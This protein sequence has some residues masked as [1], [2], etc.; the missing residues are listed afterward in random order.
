MGTV[1]DAL[2]NAVAESFF[3]TLECELLDRYDWPTRQ[4]LRTAVFDFLEVFYNRQRRH[5]TIDYLTPSTTST[6]PITSTRRRANLST[7]AGQ[8]QEPPR[9]RVVIGSW[10]PIHGHRSQRWFWHESSGCELAIF[11]SPCLSWWDR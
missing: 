3:A 6:N 4:A 5:S 7:K 11:S 2:D 9:R 1:G 8:L 10:P